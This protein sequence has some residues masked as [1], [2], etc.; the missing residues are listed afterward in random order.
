[1]SSISRAAAT[2]SCS[3][4]ASCR[5]K[6]SS[7]RSSMRPT[8]PAAA[9]WTKAKCRA[10]HEVVIG[11]W[12]TNGNSA[13]CWSASIAAIILSMSAASA[14]ASAQDKVRRHHA[15]AEGGGRRARALQRQGRAEEDPRVH[16]VKPELVAEIEFA[17]WTGDGMCGR[18]RSRGCAR[19]AGRGGGGGEAGHDQKLRK[20]GD[21]QAKPRRTASRAKADGKSAEVMGVVISNP[22]RRCGR[23]PATARRVTKLDLA[24]YYEAVG[25]WMIGHHQGPAVLDHPRARWHRRRN[26][27]PAP[28]DAGHS[29]LLELVKVSGDRKPYLQIDRVEGLVAVAQIGGV[30][31]H[32]W[33]CEP[34]EPEVPGRL[35]FDLDPAP[36]VDF[37]M[38]STPPRKCGSGWSLG[39]VSFCKTTGGKGLHVVTPLA[40]GAKD[41]VSW[42][43][44]KAFAQGVCQRMAADSPSAIWSTCR[45]SSARA[46][47]SSTIC[48]TTAC[49][50]RSRRCRRA[51]AK[52]PRSRCR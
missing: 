4:P 47:S 38:S 12:T 42:K 18:P 37:A 45:R 51:R 19:Q 27:L 41:K 44:A 20:A 43:E 14:P 15:G 22:T 5:S 9:N 3:R 10:G 31:L 36:D 26:V 23:T 7:P 8:G 34:D 46:T 17:G 30:E 40:H 21:Q 39:L 50:R 25:D 24:R 49:R 52:A 13:R 35:V 32:P 1:M 29:N 11:G 28:R 33:N 16:W 2:R 6:A 48:A